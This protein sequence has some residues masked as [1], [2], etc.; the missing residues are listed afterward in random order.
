MEAIQK[1]QNE[2]KDEHQ[3]IINEIQNSA[4][5]ITNSFVNAQ[6]QKLSAHAQ[7]LI[8]SIARYIDGS[9]A[10]LKNK[11]SESSADVISQFQATS[12]ELVML[13][14]AQQK[15]LEKI[16]SDHAD[17]LHSLHQIQDRVLVGAEHLSFSNSRKK[18]RGFSDNAS[19]DL[20]HCTCAVNAAIGKLDL[21]SHSKLRLGNSKWSFCK[22]TEAF[23]I[24]DRR[25]P[26]W[27]SSRKK[28]TYRFHSQI[29]GWLMSG[30]LELRRSPNIAFSGWTILP[31]LNF[32]PVVSIDA[33][34]FRVILRH[35]GYSLNNGPASIENCLRDL[36]TVF[37]SGHGS[38]WDVLE[39]G[40]SLL[41]VS[42]FSYQRSVFAF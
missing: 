28:T 39:T 14:R 10:S 2:N 9:G 40:K 35:L 32:R 34:S 15:H 6:D 22:N 11:I 25:C 21:A 30:S 23:I 24:H 3:E 33:P 36:R 31:S 13:N 12:T 17:M 5:K 27:Y 7:T 4:T 18:K 42:C 37:R 20:S 29:V 38:P 41:Q 1:A 16:A 19:T 8:T 26:M